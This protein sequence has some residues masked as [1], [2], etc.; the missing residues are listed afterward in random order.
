[1]QIGEFVD[2]SLHRLHGIGDCIANFIFDSVGDV[3]LQ[4]LLDLLDSCCDNSREVGSE[5]GGA[6]FAETDDKSIRDGDGGK[7]GEEA[8]GVRGVRAVS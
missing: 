7:R 8:E 3:E 2:S 5:R 6:L 1:M 4:A